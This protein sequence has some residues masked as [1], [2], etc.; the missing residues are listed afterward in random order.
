[1]RVNH[2]RPPCAALQ[3]ERRD[4][5]EAVAQGPACNPGQEVDIGMR[6][7][8]VHGDETIA[9]SASDGGIQ[10]ACSKFKGW[11]NATFF[12]GKQ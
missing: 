8:L 12:G 11:V 9:D 7:I 5:D 4:Y 6:V 10:G 3:E 1:M 2:A